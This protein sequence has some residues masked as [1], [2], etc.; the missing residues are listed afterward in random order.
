MHVTKDA[1]GGVKVDVDP[2][3][4]A[5]VEKEGLSEVDPVIIGM[6]PA[7]VQAIFGVKNLANTP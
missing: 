4:I 3:L 2:S 6:L 7:D 5:R 1:N